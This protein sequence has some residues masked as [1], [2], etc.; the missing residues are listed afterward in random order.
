MYSL[1]D[2][3]EWSKI[4]VSI[5]VPSQSIRKRLSRNF[6]TIIILSF[7]NNPENFAKF[8]SAFQKLDH[9]TCNAILRINRNEVNGFMHVIEER[10][11]HLLLSNGLTF[12]LYNIF[13]P[14]AIKSVGYSDHK[15][16]AVRR[17]GGRSEIQLLLQS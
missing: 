8:H 15:R 1:S 2:G 12:E 11:R 14:S 13:Y 10:H 4:K 16:Q 3:G 5:L 17:A 9:L 6:V 7:G